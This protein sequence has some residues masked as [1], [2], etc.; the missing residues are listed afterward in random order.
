MLYNTYQQP[1]PT[2]VLLVGDAH[3][4]YKGAT[5]FEIYNK[6]PTFRGTYKLYPNFVPTYHG[7]A[8]ASGETS[9]DQRFVNISG[10]DPLPDMLIGRLS[11]QTP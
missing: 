8:P 2:Y 1:A 6:D 4:D 11:V 5:C 3:Y 7:W 10:E 9:M